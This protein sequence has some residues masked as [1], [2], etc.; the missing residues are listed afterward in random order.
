[1]PIREAGVCLPYPAGSMPG[2]P[3]CRA[4]GKTEE[5]AGFITEAGYELF[6]DD[7]MVDEGDR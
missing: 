5:K 2:L 4:Q 3:E 6:I 1:M 7:E